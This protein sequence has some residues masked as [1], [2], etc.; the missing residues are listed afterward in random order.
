M[1]SQVDIFSLMYQTKMK[2]K[3]NLTAVN[4]YKKYFAEVVLENIFF[5]TTEESS[6]LWHE[7]ID[8]NANHYFEL[9]STSWLI[10]AEKQCLT[11][12]IESFNNGDYE[13]VKSILSQ[14]VIWNDDD[15]IVFFISS[16]ISFSCTW[17]V[18]KENWSD[19]LSIDD[20]CPVVINEINDNC[21]LLFSVSGSLYKIPRRRN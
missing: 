4:S 8:P 7:L 19:F 2:Q 9:T 5:N 3:K 17:K 6:S 12:W 14:N 1:V 15:E 18:F 13:L 11:N 21:I 10:S 20:E 16:S